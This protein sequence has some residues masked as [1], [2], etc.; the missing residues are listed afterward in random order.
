MFLIE[1]LMEGWA[2]LGVI[3]IIAG[4][5]GVFLP[6]LPGTPLIFTGALLLDYAR[7]W[8]L[9]GLGWL[10]VMGVLTLISV[11][12]DVWLSNMAAKRGG[13]SWLALLV[14][15]VL[16]MVGLVLLPPFGLVIGSVV[17]VAGTEWLRERNSGRA[18]QAGGSW[19]IGWVLGRAF[20]VVVALVMLAIIL[21]RSGVLIWS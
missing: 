14:G 12:A 6:V 2:L 21:Y 11:V 4:L 20:E 8:S 5:F 7:G 1:R 16:G 17:G 18:L 13:A 15:L 3:S 10:T 19:V 9:F